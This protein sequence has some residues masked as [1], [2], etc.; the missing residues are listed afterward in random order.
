MPAALVLD[1]LLVIALVAFLIS[2][3]RA[4]FARSLGSILGVIA[5]GV[6]VFLLMPV[7]A[8][9]VP[10]PFWRMFFIVTASILF[11]AAGH[12]VGS[13][14]GRLVGR[15]VDRTV[16][17]PLDRVLGGAA[18]LVTAALVT[19][20][21]AGGLGALGAPLL[22]SAAQGSFIVSGIQRLTPEPVDSALARLRAAVFE[23][24]VPVL[25]QEIGGITTSPGVPD[26]VETTSD[27]LVQASAS[28]VRITGTAYACGQNQ[29]GTGFVV[30]RDRVVTNAHVVAG[31]AE[32]VVQAPN[33]QNVSG[34]VVYF[35]PRI[36][37]AVIAT[38]ALAVAPLALDGRLSIGEQA[39]VQGY[40]FGGPFA[41]APAEVLAISTE[42]LR[43]IYGGSS[44]EREVY[45]LATAISPGNSGGPL[46]ALD[47]EVAGVIFAKG[48]G[49]ATLGYALTNSE[50]APV[51]TAAP[52]LRDTVTAGRC[53]V[54]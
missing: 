36:D 26:D 31:V 33:G 21:V 9:I 46:L 10:W 43:D 45:S 8:G 48:A 41:A 52:G 6:A 17:R 11:L 3:L 14:L 23:Q 25:E 28:V 20:L 40:P 4:G 47:G 16:L 22:S 1:A 7:L 27:P 2:G 13:A 24:G 35:D 18:T 42:R 37:L 12:A 54:G 51:V 19:S 53:V 30:A 34:R 5:G 29:S 50:L 32:P 39:V 44:S 15:G 49:D 38:E